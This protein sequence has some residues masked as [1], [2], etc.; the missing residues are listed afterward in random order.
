MAITGK[1]LALGAALLINSSLAATVSPGDRDVIQ[2]QQQQR[3][4]QNQQ[5]ARQMLRE[6][7]RA[8]ENVSGNLIGVDLQGEVLQVSPWARN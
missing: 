3:L 8:P 6:F 5:Q 1:W 4:E 7:R 2:N